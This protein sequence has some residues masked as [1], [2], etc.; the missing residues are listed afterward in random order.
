MKA[1]IA[2]ALLV[3]AVSAG[4][5]DLFNKEQ[6]I[7]LQEKALLNQKFGKIGGIRG[8]PVVGD[9]DFERMSLGVEGLTGGLNTVYT[10]GELYNTELFQEYMT[11]PLFRQYM[12]YN[13]F[14]KYVASP[15]FQQF[16]FST[17]GFIQYFRNPVLFYKYIYPQIQA[18]KIETEVRGIDSEL[19]RPVDN[20]NV[21]DFFRGIQG[22]NKNRFVDVER[23]VLPFVPEYQTTTPFYGQQN[24][25]VNNVNY[26]YLIEK[27]Y[28]DL[29][30]N[31]TPVTEVT[32][33]MPK[34][35]ER[36]I[37]DVITGEPKIQYQIKIVDGKIVRVPVFPVDKIVKEEIKEE[38]VKDELKK[39]LI[40]E[41]IK[42][43]LIKDTLYKDTLVKDT[44]YKDDLIKDTLFK[45]NLVKEELLKKMLLNKMAFP[46]TEEYNTE[47]LRRN[48]PAGMFKINGEQELLFPTMFNTQRFGKNM[49]LKKILLKKYLEGEK[50]V[51]PTMYNRELLTQQKEFLP[52]QQE[53]EIMYNPMY[54]REL[55]TQQKEFLPFQQEKEIMY[56][57]MYNTMLNKEAKEMIFNTEVPKTFEGKMFNQYKTLPFTT[58]E[59]LNKEIK[60]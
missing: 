32:E 18:L 21:Y 35:V 17:R 44:L 54:N 6:L 2:I 1:F 52:F 8:L 30:L 43:D 58:F 50:M 10:I 7:K 42:K 12:Q 45:D 5:L 27:I 28:R 4:P 51:T 29:L 39:D 24:F 46:M 13:I 47:I 56:N 15:I 31:K 59:Q 3:A 49:L 33:F 41:E 55:L 26:K 53:K 40:K 23:R 19:V 57:P 25:D 16:F 14:Q 22:L 37:F 34:N 48:A 20:T 38:L 9:V 11:I 60:Y 36:Q